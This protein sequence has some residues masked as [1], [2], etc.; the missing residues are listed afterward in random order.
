MRY[1]LP[2]PTDKSL[3]TVIFGGNSRAYAQEMTPKITEFEFPTRNF[4]FR[5]VYNQDTEIL[6]LYDELASKVVAMNAPPNTDSEL[7]ELGSKAITTVPQNLLFDSRGGIGEKSTPFNEYFFDDHFTG[8]NHFG[9][10][11]DDQFFYVLDG[12]NKIQVFELHEDDT[13]F[14]PIYQGEETLSMPATL[15][16][17]HDG[18]YYFVG[19]DRKVFRT[20]LNW[21]LLGTPIKLENGTGDFRH[22]VPVG[23]DILA[24][25]TEW[26]SYYLFTV[27]DKDYSNF[28][29]MYSRTVA[30][31]NRN[32]IFLESTN[33]DNQEMIVF[34][35]HKV[36]ETS[37][38]VTN[39]YDT[40]KGIIYATGAGQNKI[41]RIETNSD[42]VLLLDD[43]TRDNIRQNAETVKYRPK[44]VSRFTIQGDSVKDIQG[45]EIKRKYYNSPLDQSPKSEIII[46]A[47]YLSN[48]QIQPIV[49]I[50]K[51]LGTDL[52]GD[53]AY[54]ITVPP[55]SKNIFIIDGEDIE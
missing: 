46:P 22:F 51:L 26:F 44:K 7:T 43:E 12:T 18:H 36:L 13:H 28:I 11:Q 4:N 41:L 25:I 55:K 38:P 47:Q 34:D 8:H 35:E 49:D 31:D 32:E 48:M 45:I 21:T 23:G 16:I 29:A 53:V 27:N 17:F 2:N 33:L 30:Y 24:L 40:G 39:F 19:T 54:E 50:E 14:N 15:G 3:K 5:G 10:F 6:Y 20:D 52:N 42:N 37:F 1:V 9:K